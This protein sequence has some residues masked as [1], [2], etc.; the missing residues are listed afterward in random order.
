MNKQDKK[1]RPFTLG[2]KVFRKGLLKTNSA[3]PLSMTVSNAI[4]LLLYCIDQD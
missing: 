3:M 1:P 2:F 4:S